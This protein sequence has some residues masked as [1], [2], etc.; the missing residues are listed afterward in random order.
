[1]LLT[2]VST[3]FFNINPLIKIDG[4]Y[5][6]SSLLQLPDLRE[7]AFR[8]LG[9]GFQ[10]YVLRLPVDIPVVSK[11]KFRICLIY[12]VLS[13]T[14][15]AS[16]MFV[17]GKLFSNLY[18]KYFPEFA[19]VLLVVTL[20]YLFRKRLRKVARVGKLLYLD[21]KELLMSP[22]SR[23][24]LLGVAAIL[25]LILGIPW[26][27]RTITAQAVLRPNTDIMVQAPEEGVVTEVLVR[28]GDA[29]ERGQVLFRLISPALEADAGKSRAQEERFVRK[30][31]ADRASANAGLAF[32]S[33]SRAEAAQSA[34]KTAEYRKGFLQIRSPIAGRVLTSRTQDLEGTLVPAGQT[35][36]RIGDCRKM[37]AQAEV[38][39]R[40]LE[41]LK[42]NSPV[43][44][45]IKA[46]SARSWRGSIASISPATAGQPATAGGKDPQ[47]PSIQ[48]DRFVA[49][50]VFDNPDGRLLPGA[51]ARLKISSARASYLTRAGSVV[52]RWLRSIIW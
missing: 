43:K 34:F 27:R 40:F 46:Q 16:I 4:Y 24:Y 17:I 42:V 39:E 51:E 41:Y 12:G 19:E 52:W 6:L 3:I 10:R 31:S 14:Y 20:F 13:A 9:S 7:T 26:G 21:K 22:R 30:S 36:V 35:L 44:A 47:A 18:A 50:A 38:S 32:Q 1:M 2:G 49:M 29:V 45:L 25:L 8:L 11:R 37:V 33:N 5:A 28:E 48:P 23:W 15:T